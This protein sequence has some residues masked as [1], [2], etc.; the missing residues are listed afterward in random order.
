MIQVLDATYLPL[1]Y[2]VTRLPVKATPSVGPQ[3]KGP[4]TG[5]AM[6]PVS[7]DLRPDCES[8]SQGQPHIAR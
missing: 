6:H 1:S 5:A 3:L 7:K 8:N 2:I 4:K